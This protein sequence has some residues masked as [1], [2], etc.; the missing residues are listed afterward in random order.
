MSQIAPYSR[1]EDASPTTNGGTETHATSKNTGADG[2]DGEGEGWREQSCTSRGGWRNEV[3][4]SVPTTSM[5]VQTG[6]TERIRM[7]LYCMYKYVTVP[8][9][10]G[11]GETISNLPNR[12]DCR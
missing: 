12:F 9:A 4:W 6:K 2:D 7:E 3:W 8:R 11:A 1:A 10:R 5:H